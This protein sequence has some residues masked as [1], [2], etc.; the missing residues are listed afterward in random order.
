MKIP[1]NKIILACLISINLFLIIIYLISQFWL[2]SDIIRNQ[3]NLDGESNIPA[4][5]SSLQ[6]F[7]LFALSLFYSLKIEVKHLRRFYYLLSLLFL[8][9]SA[10]ETAMIHETIAKR[11]IADGF[12]SWMLV[13]PVIIIILGIPFLKGIS[14]FLK[15]RA[16]R[17]VFIIGACLFVA[18]GIGWEMWGYFMDTRSVLYKFSVMLEESFELFGGSLM[19]YA[20]LLK[21]SAR[22]IFTTSDVEFVHGYFSVPKI[23]PSS[24]QVSSRTSVK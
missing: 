2:T 17:A 9:F 16:G 4:W 7:S 22:G 5:F 6:F 19:I 24:Q 12:H 3:F 1:E 23:K 8:F 14:A 13:Y 21:V 10:D 18:G 15:E 11:F 20:L